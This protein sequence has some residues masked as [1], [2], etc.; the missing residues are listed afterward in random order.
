MAAPNVGVC[1]VRDPD[2]EKKTAWADSVMQDVEAVISVS[3]SLHDYLRDIAY[4]AYAANNND[5]FSPTSDGIRLSRLRDKPK[6]AVNVFLRALQQRDRGWLCH[7][8][9]EYKDGEEESK[10]EE[11]TGKEEKK[12]EVKKAG[13]RKELSNGL[14][15]ALASC[16]A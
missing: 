6:P 9:K 4:D 15:G 2:Y 3:R 5:D 11:E 16:G 1:C 14:V 8:V 7:Y 12:S 10:A 13:E